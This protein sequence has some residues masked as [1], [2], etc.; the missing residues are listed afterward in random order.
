[1]VASFLPPAAD[2]IASLKKDVA[3]VTAAMKSLREENLR[4]KV[5]LT[6][7]KLQGAG[8]Q[9]TAKEPQPTSTPPSAENQLVT[10]MRS[11]ALCQR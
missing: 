5:E 10:L 7:I 8:P 2:E 6:K 9:T 4:L 3:E 1:M 11:A